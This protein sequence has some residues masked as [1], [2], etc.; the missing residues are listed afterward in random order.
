V[1]HRIILDGSNKWPKRLGTMPGM[2]LPALSEADVRTLRMRYNAAY[3]AYQGCVLALNEA[4]MAGPHASQQLLD[5]EAAAL[6]ELTEARG[7]LL[8]AMA[9]LAAQDHH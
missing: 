4:A 7:Q 3:A 5:S 6:S 1:D 8:A 9:A 2:P